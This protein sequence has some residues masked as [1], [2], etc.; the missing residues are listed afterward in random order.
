[1]SPACSCRI[2]RLAGCAA[3]LLALAA[4]QSTEDPFTH[5]GSWR[6]EGLNDANIA[7]QVANPRHLVMGAADESSPGV[8]SNNAVERLL[9]DKVKRLPSTAYGPITQTSQQAGGQ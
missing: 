1:M 3:A 5:P 2:L 4:C 7:A 9:S 8:L 6:P